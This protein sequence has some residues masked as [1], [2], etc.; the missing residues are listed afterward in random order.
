MKTAP[1]DV[2]AKMVRFDRD[3]IRQLAAEPE[4]CATFF[5][6]SGQGD[7][8]F[9]STRQRTAQGEIYADIV[10]GAIQRPAAADAVVD[11]EQAGG[12]LVQAYADQGFP[13]EDMAKL[14][15]VSTLPAGEVC[16]VAN[17]YMAAVASLGEER[18]GLLYRSMARD[19]GV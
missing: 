10:E 4:H 13:V 1:S 12:W 3:I 9:L 11:Q 17:E 18:I 14:A 19:G 8:S 7:F 16:R 6:A 15:E 5:K 2:L